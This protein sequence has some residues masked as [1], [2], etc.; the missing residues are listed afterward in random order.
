MTIYV[1]SYD[2][3][4]C[5]ACLGIPRKWKINFFLYLN[6]H[7]PIFFFFDHVT[8]KKKKQEESCWNLKS[9]CTPSQLEI[10]LKLLWAS[11]TCHDSKSFEW[12]LFYKLKKKH[13]ANISKTRDLNVR[14]EFSKK[15][16][17]E[18]QCILLLN[19]N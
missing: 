5:C 6:L 9:L 8:K 10:V 18:K 4:Q 14:I 17:K 3:D 15:K 12:V 16:R 19:K 7:I 11:N 1:R 2:S 13:F